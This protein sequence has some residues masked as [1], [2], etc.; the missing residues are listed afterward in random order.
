MNYSIQIQNFKSKLTITL[1]KENLKIVIK[2]QPQQLWKTHKV[3]IE[4]ISLSVLKEIIKQNRLP[5]E[6]HYDFSNTV[7]EWTTTNQLFTFKR[8]DDLIICVVKDN[9]SDHIYLKEE[10]LTDTLRFGMS[11]AEYNQLKERKNADKE[12]AIILA[13]NI[14]NTLTLGINFEDTQK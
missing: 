1:I 9:P 10:E 8:E 5:I 12:Q 3:R 11:F 13:G 4:D 2:T 7:V 14:N 6:K